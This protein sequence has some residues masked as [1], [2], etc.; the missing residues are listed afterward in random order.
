MCKAP[1]AALF[2]GGNASAVAL[3]SFNRAKTASPLSFRATRALRDME[4]YR[5]TERQRRRVMRLYERAVEL[6][7]GNSSGNMGD[8]EDCEYM[9]G[10]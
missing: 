6:C 10:V 7:I 4:M 3:V 8:F 2:K 5:E 1:P 9:C